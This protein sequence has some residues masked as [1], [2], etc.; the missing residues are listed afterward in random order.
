V[1]CAGRG[2][3]SGIA[4]SG[5]W[6]LFGR[7]GR[8]RL[9]ARCDDDYSGTRYRNRFFHIDTDLSACA[10]P[11]GAALRHSYTVR[12]PMRARWSH[13]K[14]IAGGARGSDEG[15]CAE[16]HATSIGK[17]VQAVGLSFRGAASRPSNCFRNLEKKKAA[18]ECRAAAAVSMPGTLF[19]RSFKGSGLCGFQA[20]AVAE[21]LT[22]HALRPRSEGG[23]HAIGGESTVAGESDPIPIRRH[24]RV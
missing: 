9:S 23:L 13:R 24:I 14:G 17:Q 16:G 22:S 15:E 8:C 6:S 4:K 20:L 1:D 10:P 5:E 12:Q 18:A 3:I 7:S 2:S 19:V 21:R 11:Q